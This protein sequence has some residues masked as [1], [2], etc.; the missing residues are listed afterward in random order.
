[1]SGCDHDI[2]NTCDV[3][4][5]MWSWHVQCMWCICRDVVMTY[6]TLAMYASGCD[7]DICRTCDI[8]FG[9]WSQ[10][11]QHMWRICRILKCKWCG[12]IAH[13][14]INIYIYIYI[15]IHR[16]THTRTR[17][18]THTNTHTHTYI[19]AYTYTYTT[20]Q[21]RINLV[22]SLVTWSILFCF[23]LFY[24][25]VLITSWHLRNLI[26]LL[27]LPT[28]QIAWPKMQWWRVFPWHDIQKK[29]QAQIS[30]GMLFRVSKCNA[31]CAWMST[32][33]GF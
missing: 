26:S 2:H 31:N 24:M 11:I 13:R 18:H 25:H 12:I 7:H 32:S 14:F 16:Y 8:Y 19:H 10:H 28:A 5:G 23:G 3:Y 30:R 29:N 1:M 21:T 6:T 4:V 17:K 33:M 9:I 22:L 27:P 20:A 15:Y